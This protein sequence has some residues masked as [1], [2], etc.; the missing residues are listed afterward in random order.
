MDSKQSNQMYMSDDDRDYNAPNKEQRPSQYNDWDNQD[1]NYDYNQN[2]NYDYDYQ[3]DN[4]NYDYNQ[5]YDPQAPQD[6]QNDMGFKT[7][8]QNFDNHFEEQKKPSVKPILR[9]SERQQLY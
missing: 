4:Q 2:Q 3:Y 5:T 8:E 1:Q 9:P 7:D 6:P